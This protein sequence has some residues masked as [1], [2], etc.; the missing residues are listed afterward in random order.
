MSKEEEFYIKMCELC[1]VSG[2]DEDEVSALV[3][4]VA[5]RLERDG[6]GLEISLR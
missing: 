6:D 2:F 5:Q 4:L 3:L 1:G